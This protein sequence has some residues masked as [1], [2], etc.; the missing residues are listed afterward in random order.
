[1]GLGG[2]TDVATNDTERTTLS[3]RRTP[4]LDGASLSGEAQLVVLLGPTVGQ[5]IPV[6][7]ELVLGR[8][9]PGLS[10][11][12]DSVSRRHATLTRGTDGSFTIRDLGS[13]N[14]TFVN[15]QKIEEATLRIGDRIAIGGHTVLQLVLRDKFEDQRLQAQ[16]LQALGELAG[17]ISHDF[18]NLL[19]VVLANVSHLQMLERVSETDVRRVL[20]DIEAAARRAAE[21]THDLM[22]FARSGVRTFEPCD[23]ADIVEDV[24]RLLGRGL[25]RHLEL[26]TDVEPGLVVRGDAARLG[27]VLTNIGLNAIAAMPQGGTLR[28]TTRRCED[29]PPA[30]VEDAVLAP[31]G[32]VVL[33][34]IEDTGV[35]MDENVSR[36]AFEPFFTTRP[37]GVGTGLG[38]AT[39]RAIV[40]DH[41]GHIGVRSQVGRGTTVFVI[42]PLRQGSTGAREARTIDERAPLSGVVLVADDE[43]LVRSATHRVLE[44]A[45]LQ[46]VSAADGEEAVRLFTAEPSRFD[47]VILDLDMPG[48]NGEEVLERLRE[49]DP[50]ARVLISS[51]YLDQV[52]E[53]ALRGAGIDGILD[54]PYDSLTLLR[55]VANVIRDGAR[56]K[57]R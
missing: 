7:E 35:G 41:G 22:A 45:G 54:K 2:H 51:G 5:T 3:M 14:G 29:V 43:E 50:G 33:V 55:A 47:V 4:L 13:R 48:L 11:Q 24:A 46:V 6:G 9:T 53:D 31:G 42:L 36:R 16:K 44:H 40:R 20:G 12:D 34:T 8:A 27:Q 28:I 18:N 17:G 26:H 49:L 10:I 30:F 39:A 37:R 23:V 56:R 32:D 19:G 38:L 21:L 52:R 15:G 25:P 57:T 1:M